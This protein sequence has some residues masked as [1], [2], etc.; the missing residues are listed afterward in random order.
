MS[1]LARRRL[2]EIRTLKGW[3]EAY[4]IAGL[5]DEGSEAT[6]RRRLSRYI[7]RQTSGATELDSKQREKINRAYRYREKRGQFTEARAEKEIKAINKLRAQGRKQVRATFGADGITPDEAK[8]QRRLRQLRNLTAEDKRRIR[9]AYAKAKE[10]GGA[11]IRAEYAR[12][13]SRIPAASLPPTQRKDFER[14]LRKATLAVE[15]DKA[16]A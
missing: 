1:D 10:D 14:R 4:R 9:E 8:L 11:E 3:R 2:K 15:R 16:R 7:N 13:L 6:R 12:L 5:K